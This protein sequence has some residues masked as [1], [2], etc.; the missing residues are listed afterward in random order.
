MSMY[1]IKINQSLS[2]TKVN[3]KKYQLDDDVHTD[4]WQICLS[5][6]SLSFVE[7]RNNLAMDANTT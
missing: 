6:G 4:L 5:I 1:S 2:T 7:R 3:A